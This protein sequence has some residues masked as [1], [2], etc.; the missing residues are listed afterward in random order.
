[1][2]IDKFINA[3]DVFLNAVCGTLIVLITLGMFIQVI[4]RYLTNTSSGI[5]EEGLPVLMIWLSMLICGYIYI[6]GQHINTDLVFTVLKGKKLTVLKVFISVSV[7][8]FAV[9][10]GLAGWQ[11]TKVMLVLGQRSGTSISYPLWT[12]EISLVIGMALLILYSLIDLIRNLY[13]LFPGQKPGIT[14]MKDS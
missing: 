4:F 11:Q 2:L 5:A 10:F 8:I 14:E 7:L 12:T 6:R 3:L 1:M 9:I 13:E